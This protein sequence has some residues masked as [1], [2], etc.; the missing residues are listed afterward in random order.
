V[1]YEQGSDTE[2]SSI[3]IVH[4]RLWNVDLASSTGFVLLKSISPSPLCRAWSDLLHSCPK[5][6]TLTWHSSSCEI[7]SDKDGSRYFCQCPAGREVRSDSTKAAATPTANNLDVKLIGSMWHFCVSSRKPDWVRK[8]I[9]RDGRLDN[10]PSS[11]QSLYRLI[12]RS[13]IL[14]DNNSV[15]LRER[16]VW[17][18]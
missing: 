14:C 12:C 2:P 18:A 15:L 7:V 3:V 9:Y 1:S 8:Q 16:R 5:K 11:R 4:V 6:M 13:S 10:K 17:G